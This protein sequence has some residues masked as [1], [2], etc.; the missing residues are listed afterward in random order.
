MA[1]GDLYFEDVDIG[2]D[3][4]SVER[5]VT[6]AQVSDFVKGWALETVPNRFTSSDVAS[7]EGLPGP[8]VPGAISVAM[9]AQLLSA[10]SATVIFR[11]LDVVFRQLVLHNVPLHLK[12]VVT[13]KNVVGGEAQ[14]DCDV[15][16]E[17]QDGARLVIGNA[18]V[19]LPQ[20]GPDN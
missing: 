20:R 18:T 8:I 10:W 4:G 5:V 14:L 11:K 1:G 9:M 2:D 17:D 19:A 6:D 13:D 16:M 3:L 15:F 12:G 7:K